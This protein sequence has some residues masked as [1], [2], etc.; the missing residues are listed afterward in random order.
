LSPSGLV[1][2]LRGLTCVLVTLYIVGGLLE[3]Y[4]IGVVGFE[5]VRAFERVKEID[6]RPVGQVYGGPSITGRRDDPQDVARKSRATTANLGYAIKEARA[7]II[8]VMT[9]SARLRISGAL[10]L[11]LGLILSVVG[12]IISAFQ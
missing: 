8:H 2:T 4:G 6:D 5:L 12:N 1:P 7:D 10:A 3:A 11:A 9:A